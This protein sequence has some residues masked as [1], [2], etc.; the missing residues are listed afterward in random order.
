MGGGGGGGGCSSRIQL[1]THTVS[2]KRKII[3]LTTCATW[4]HY[5]SACKWRFWTCW[6][7]LHPSLP[8]SPGPHGHVHAHTVSSEKTGG[9][10]VPLHS[11]M[12]SNGGWWLADDCSASEALGSPVPAP[13][14]APAPS[15]SS[16]SVISLSPA[17]SSSSSSVSR[18][19]GLTN[20]TSAASSLG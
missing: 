18:P 4:T 13:A 5:V 15:S 9:Y 11:T 10:E 6:L 7:Q 2:S 16:A 3:S 17:G 19:N 20:T 8:F 12:A 14:P 1:H